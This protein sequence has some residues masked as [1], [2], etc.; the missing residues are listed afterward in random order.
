MFTK[1]LYFKLKT[2]KGQWDNGN[3]AGAIAFLE[4]LPL[5]EHNPNH[6]NY[7]FQISLTLARLYRDVGDIPKARAR[8]EMAHSIRPHVEA[9]NPI[10]DPGSH[11]NP[12]N[13]AVKYVEKG[14]EGVQQ[15]CDLCSATGFR[16][17]SEVQHEGT[18]NV[19]KKRLF[20]LL[21]LK[22]VVELTETARSAKFHRDFW[23]RD[24]ESLSFYCPTCR[25]FFSRRKDPNY[26]N[27]FSVLP[28]DEEA[29]WFKA[30]DRDNG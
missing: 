14:K 9:L 7:L 13:E 3:R 29:V 17:A 22:E 20:G 30:Y 10:S 11:V 21:G 8:I 25:E 18:R 27:H 5:D 6:P 12:L 2:A 19:Y 28:D 24:G 23:E 4:Q 16:P 15:S 26:Y 1:D